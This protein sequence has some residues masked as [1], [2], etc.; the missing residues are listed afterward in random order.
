MPAIPTRSTSRR[1]WSSLINFLRAAAGLEGYR[2]HHH[3]GRFRRLVRPRLCEATSPSF[4]AEAD[5]LNGPGKC[6]AGDA[7]QPGVDGK[8]VNGRCGPGTRLPFLVISPWA[9]ANYVS[10]TRISQASVVRFIEDNWLHG[11]RLGGG[12][13]DATAGLDHGHVRLQARSG[14]TAALYLDPATGTPLIRTARQRADRGRR[15]ARDRPLTGATG[16]AACAGARHAARSTAC[17]AIAAVAASAGR[18]LQPVAA[19]AWAPH[20]GASCMRAPGENPDPVSSCARRPPRCR[21]WRSSG[22][23][24]FYDT[25]LSSS[26]RLSCASCH[27]PAHAYGPP[28]DAPAMTGGPAL[29]RQGVR[30]VPSLMY[31]ERQPN[32]SIGPDNEENETVNLAQTGRGRP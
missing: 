13:F 28:G 31:L 4:D 9:K 22:R 5:Q 27:S 29:S 24:I 14:N 10:H 3:L 16:I 1:E 20:P 12:S 2:G 26:G 11:E 30:A 6:G 25:G 23:L 8:P 18:H 21:R 32:F 17:A 7:A 15:H 19:H